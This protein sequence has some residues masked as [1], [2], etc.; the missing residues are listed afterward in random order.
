MHPH[1]HIQTPVH[2]YSKHQYKHRNYCIS[3]NVCTDLCNIRFA[4]NI[5]VQPIMVFKFK[6][7]SYLSITFLNSKSI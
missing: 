4:S 1:I 7:S 2:T 6:I 5:H 3:F